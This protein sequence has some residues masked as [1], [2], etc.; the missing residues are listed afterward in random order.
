MAAATKARSVTQ[1]G[2]SGADRPGLASIL[3]GTKWFRGT[4]LVGHGSR[5]MEI[6]RA[7]V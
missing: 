5:M 7:H 6:G 4:V 2:T 1:R 3:A